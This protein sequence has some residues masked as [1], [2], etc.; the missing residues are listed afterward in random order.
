MATMDLRIGII[1]LFLVILGILGNFSLASHYLFLYFH[2]HRLRPIDLILKHLTVANFLGIIL[3]GI[4]ETMAALGMEYFLS[5]FG[6][7][8]IFYIHRVGRGVSYGC[9]CLLSIFQAITISPRNSKWAKLKEKTPRYINISTILC[10]TLHLLV[11]AVFPIRISGKWKNTNATER[12]DNGVCSSP[13]YDK[14]INSIFAALFSIS[15]VLCLGLMLWASGSM[16]FILYRHKQQVQ[17]IQ[18]SDI[19]SRSSAETR[20]THSILAL[21]STFM[22]FYAITSV[23]Q[24]LLAVFHSPSVWLFSL[25]TLMDIFFPTVCPFVIMTR[26][27]NTSRIYSTCCGSNIKSPTIIREKTHV[28][29]VLCCIE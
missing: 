3:R 6:C 24:V 25:A 14:V 19:S 15:D 20:A 21:V 4:P 10:W 11:N 12:L 2:G 18:R 17:H 1:S 8:L 27:Y 16:V 9:V 5:D 7:K 23:I 29:S 28:L 22:C 13:P 26:K